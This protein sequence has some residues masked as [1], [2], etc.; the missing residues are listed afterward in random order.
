MPAAADGPSFTDL[1]SAPTV[2]EG[3]DTP[4]FGFIC[5]HP[6]PWLFVSADCY[7][8]IGVGE[9][10]YTYSESTDRIA[11]YAYGTTSTGKSFC[12]F[13]AVGSIEAG[14]HAYPVPVSIGIA[15]ACMAALHLGD[16]PELYFLVTNA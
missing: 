9:V 8:P 10:K 2:Q 1:E 13:G 7:S 14:Q 3:T 4:Q 12:I 5:S 16:P 11:L 15:A 6:S